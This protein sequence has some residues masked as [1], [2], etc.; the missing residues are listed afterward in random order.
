M[1]VLHY[2]ELEDRLERSGIGTSIDQQRKALSKNDNITVKERLGENPGILESRISNAGFDVVH[3]NFVGPKSLA[4]ARRVSGDVPLVLHAHMTAEDFGESFRFSNKLQPLVKRYLEKFYGYA[5]LVLC[6]SNYTKSRLE[7][8]YNINSELKVIT[9]GVDTESLEGFQDIRTE[10]RDKFNL[11][12]TTVFTVGNVFERKGLSTFIK[13]AKELPEFD[14]VW[15]GPYDTGPQ[16]SKIVKEKV[17]NPPNNVTFTGWVDDKRGAFAAGDIYMFPSKEEN[18]GIAVLEAMTCEKPAILSDI[19]VFQELYEHNSDCIMCS[20]TKEYV[21]T[22]EQLD[23]N[24]E[25]VD[26]LKGNAVETA[27]EHSLERV[28]GRLENMYKGLI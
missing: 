19:P 10:Y 2:A 8:H 26:S 23:N 16:A 13:V 15:F 14:F 22:I 6:P 4:I 3:M 9:N 11:N 17:R 18:Q 24:Q 21:R 7:N 28:S 12:R 20:D 1:K 25:L 27:S 5:D